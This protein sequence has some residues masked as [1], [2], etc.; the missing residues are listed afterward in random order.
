M[1]TPEGKIKAKVSAALKRLGAYKFMPVQNGMGAPAL[2]YYC[3][4]MGHFV[5]VETKAPGKH[6]TTRQELTAEEI[7][8]A[9]GLVF[10]VDGEDTLHSM[11]ARLKHLLHT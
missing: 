2:D 3:C 9:G 7:W 11:I 4:Y 1:A 10:V 8:K 5:A 6:L